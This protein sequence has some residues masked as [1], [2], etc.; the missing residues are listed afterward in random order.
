LHRLLDKGSKCIYN[1]LGN[2]TYTSTTPKKEE[3]CTIIG[4]FFVPFGISTKD[5]ELDPPSLYWIP[6][7][8][9]RPYKQRYIAGS[10][11]C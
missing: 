2:P 1:S 8:N 11:K 3:S 4:L 10:A 9:K 7:L 5:E 6:K